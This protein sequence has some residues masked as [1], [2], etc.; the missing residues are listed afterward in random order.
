M[1]KLTRS[2]C[3]GWA[4]F[5]G[6]AI[7]SHANV[8]ATNPKFN[9]A[10]GNLAT[11]QANRTAIGYTLN[12]RADLGVTVNIFSGTNIIR[13]LTVA[14][15]TTA[16]TSFGTNIVYWD[17]YDS[18]SNAAPLGDY[19][20]TI[21]AAAS[22]HTNWTQISKDSVASTY[23]FDAQGIAVD[24]NTNS[25][26]YGRVFVGN[27]AN[28]PHAT[29][30][31][32]VPGDMDGIL[33]FNADGTFADEG[34]F[35]D[36]GYPF[37]DDSSSDVPQ[38]MRMG[39][40]DRL[41]MNDLYASQIAAFDPLLNGASIVFTQNNWANNPFAGIISSFLNPTPGQYGW[42]GM[43]IT[44]AASTNGIIWLGDADTNGAGIWYWHLTNGMADPND[45]T[46]TQAIAVGGSLGVAA[47]GGLMVDGNLDIF[48]AQDLTDLGDTNAVCMEFTNWAG[49]N[50]PVTNGTAWMAGGTNNSFLDVYD[51]TIDSRQNP[52]YVACA[53]SGPTA[54]GIRIL[55]ASNG[56]VL[57][58]LDTTNQYFVTTWDN[59]GNLYAASGPTNRWRVFAP[60]NGPN[61][62]TTA[63]QKVISIVKTPTILS[64]ALQGTNS[65]I[66]FTGTS[67]NPPSAFH[68]LS[69]PMVQGPYITNTVGLIT[70]NINP[71]FFKATIPQSGSTGFYQIT[72]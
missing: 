48:V 26:Y 18:N 54:S 25:P 37:I 6:S 42:F 52:K 28:G 5:F 15:N 13:T 30:P 32:V 1:T 58:T 27:A 61:Q 4:I 7:A 47:S 66:N 64:I 56:A 19:T 20:V 40:D 63:I 11:A 65:V 14:S 22:G 34:A 24:N 35:G 67:T 12:E 59:V 55:N 70:T 10:F 50:P 38:K 39:E 45:M 41:Y 69:S 3:T 17:G 57:T 8:Y 21:T 51:T 29:R 16:G 23:I 33:K 31:P 2:L 68:I 49:G 53:L 60:P 36:S 44:G 71:G 46:G 43:D 9:G 72:R 62:S